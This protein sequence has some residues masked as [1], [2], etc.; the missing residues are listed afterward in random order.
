MPISPLMPTMR[1][2]GSGRPKYLRSRMPTCLAAD[3]DHSPAQVDDRQKEGANDAHDNRQRVQLQTALSSLPQKGAVM[4]IGS[5]SSQFG[6]T[7]LVLSLS[8]GSS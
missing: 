8:K 4:A 1:P 6:S 3:V 5:R 2:G 7:P